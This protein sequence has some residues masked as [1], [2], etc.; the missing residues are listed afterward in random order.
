MRFNDVYLF[1]GALKL[2][3]FAALVAAKTVLLVLVGVLRRELISV[4]L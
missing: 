4:L 3:G 1:C 2:D